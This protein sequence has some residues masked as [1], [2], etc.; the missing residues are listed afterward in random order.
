M[1]P[2]IMSLDEEQ[3]KHPGVS[4]QRKG[5]KTGSALIDSR[6]SRT[7]ENSGLLRVL[8]QGL[9][10]LHAPPGG[11]PIADGSSGPRVPLPTSRSRP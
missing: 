1:A 3:S 2:L 11:A 6:A 9:V 4:F 10:R 8:K 7:V 5:D